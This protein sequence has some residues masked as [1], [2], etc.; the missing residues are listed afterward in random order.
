MAWRCGVRTRVLACVLCSPRS[1]AHARKVPIPLHASFPSTRSLPLPTHAPCRPA[2]IDFGPSLRAVG[3]FSSNTIDLTIRA[4][5]EGPD[6]QYKWLPTFI[7]ARATPLYDSYD[8]QITYYDES[9]TS[10]DLL[11]HMLLPHDAGAPDAGLF[12]SVTEPSICAGATTNWPTELA[13]ANQFTRGQDNILGIGVLTRIYFYTNCNGYAGKVTCNPCSFTF[14]GLKANQIG[15]FKSPGVL[16]R[17]FYPYNEPP[18]ARDVFFTAPLTITGSIREPSTETCVSGLTME[19]VEISFGTGG[20]DLVLNSEPAYPTFDGV[21]V[22]THGQAHASFMS[23]TT[24]ELAG[25]S[26]TSDRYTTLTFT[27]SGGDLIIDLRNEASPVADLVYTLTIR[28]GLACPPLGSGGVI[29]ELLSGAKLVG[30][31]RALTL[32]PTV[33][34]LEATSKVYRSYET[35]PAAGH[36][37]I[38]DIT[39]PAPA[40]HWFDTSSY[41]VRVFLSGDTSAGRNLVTW[42]L[43]WDNPAGDYQNAF[44]DASATSFAIISSRRVPCVG[45]EHYNCLLRFGVTISMTDNRIAR[46]ESEALALRVVVHRVITDQATS[47]EPIMEGVVMPHLG[48]LTQSPGVLVRSFA[49]TGNSLSLSSTSVS[50]EIDLA[51]GRTPRLRYDLYINGQAATFTEARGY[52]NDLSAEICNANR[53]DGTGTVLVSCMPW[54]L[55]T[56]PTYCSIPNHPDFFNCPSIQRRARS[57][58]L[59]FSGIN[60]ESLITGALE[61][62]AHSILFSLRVY[63]RSGATLTSSDAAIATYPLHVGSGTF[64]QPVR[65]MQPILLKTVT[66][67][68]AA[69]SEGQSPTVDFS[70]ATAYTVRALLPLHTRTFP[71]NAKIRIDANN[72]RRAYENIDTALDSHVT[73]GFV[74]HDPSCLLRSS[75]GANPN[76]QAQIIDLGKMSGPCLISLQSMVLQDLVLEVLV[77]G[78]VPHN[79]GPLT[80]T[81]FSTVMSAGVSPIVFDMPLFYFTFPSPEA[82]DQRFRVSLSG[83]ETATA[84]Y[85]GNDI[86]ISLAN[87]N[88]VTFFPRDE[89]RL[90]WGHSGSQE[91]AVRLLRTPYFVHTINATNEKTYVAASVLVDI[92]PLQLEAPRVWSIRPQEALTHNAQGY[93]SLVVPFLVYTTSDINPADLPVSHRFDVWIRD[94]VNNQE[95]LSWMGSFTEKMTFPPYRA[96]M[97]ARYGISGGNAYIHMYVDHRSE[98]IGQIMTNAVMRVQSPLDFQGD[99]SVSTA[100]GLIAPSSTPLPALSSARVRYFEFPSSVGNEP[101]Y[102]MCPISVDYATYAEPVVTVDT[103][104]DTRVRRF[105]AAAV[106]DGI[107]N[108]VA[109]P[110]KLAPAPAVICSGEI[111]P[112]YYSM[113]ANNFE[114][115]ARFRLSVSINTDA[116]SLKVDEVDF[117]YIVFPVGGEGFKLPHAA[118]RSS[119]NDVICSTFN[120]TA[121]RCHVI[122]FTTI[123]TL[124]FDIDTEIDIPETLTSW[125]S[126][127]DGSS[128]AAPYIYITRTDGITSALV[129]MWGG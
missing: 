128:S 96:K 29:I 93:W 79:S 73:A 38:S 117:I 4:T 88:A 65:A 43:P 64:A 30:Q 15:A 129:D 120:A 13:V 102:V 55:V 78:F 42:S 33:G 111:F 34:T 80:V 61:G 7:G 81:Y 35:E 40:G 87:E 44:I 67:V 94:G 103:Y 92:A 63:S 125:L 70:S 101:L 14:V 51:K 16:T 24:V 109:I 99:C 60:L 104:Y 124:G 57:V 2:T 110:P 22:R 59:T 25:S 122:S 82:A 53:E 69:S 108:G 39:I 118:F 91:M 52:L 89:F 1:L 45:S 32:V 97:S 90:D 26:L 28:Y 115:A 62:S 74:G 10:S 121:F 66:S 106:I 6:V 27:T 49:H 84:H 3:F 126:A 98:T 17:A 127:L 58:L 72:N 77:Y 114:S 119:T 56:V 36:E 112:K 37:F 68:P 21:R 50:F 123:S 71:T 85:A 41:L 107:W 19:L 86:I 12:I 23:L 75:I 54:G 46:A 9:E 47:A 11:F 105:S 76:S 20:I 48:D 8:W 100:L 5:L 113:Q 116:Y 83:H 31:T 18:I 95:D